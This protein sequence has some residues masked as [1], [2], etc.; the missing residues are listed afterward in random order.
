ME[1]DMKSALKAAMGGDRSAFCAVY[2]QMKTPVFTVAYRITQSH[3]LAEDVTQDVFLKLLSLPYDPSVKNP[4]AFIFRIAHNSAIDALRKRRD[5]DELGDYAH[6]SEDCLSD[7]V[8][9]RLDIEKAMEYLS[10]SEREIVSLRLNGGLTYAET[11]RVV[12]MSLSAVYR[13]YRTALKTLQ[14]LL[15]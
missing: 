1:K 2:E 13:T 10:E 4:R 3:E 8:A 5:T 6:P 9:M 14:S 7:R 12:G 15:N 11:A